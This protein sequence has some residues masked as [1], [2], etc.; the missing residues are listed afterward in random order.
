MADA[1]RE[2]ARVTRQY[3]DLLA[4][5][6]PQFVPADLGDRGVFIRV[7][8]GPFAS[9]EAARAACDALRARGAGCNVVR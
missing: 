7:Q 4:G 2:W 8:A 1:Q 5:M 9:P 3:P 6:S